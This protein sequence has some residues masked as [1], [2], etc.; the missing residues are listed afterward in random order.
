[1]LE[2]RKFLNFLTVTLW[3]TLNVST[4]HIILACEKAYPTEHG[5][6]FGVVYYGFFT[7]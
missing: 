3:G 7:L 1:M 4:Q 6:R 2:N 5:V